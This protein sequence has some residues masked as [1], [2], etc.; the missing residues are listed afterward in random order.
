M[1]CGT[2]EAVVAAEKAV[3]H[4]CVVDKNQEGYLGSEQSQT[5]ERLHSPGFQHQGNKA[6]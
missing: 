1:Q 3:P 5:Q 2:R 6:L 4:L